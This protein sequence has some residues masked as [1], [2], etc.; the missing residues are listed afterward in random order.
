MN[1][2]SVVLK[3]G[4]VL[5]PSAGGM[6]SASTGSLQPIR[7]RHFFRKSATRFRLQL[8]GF[9][10]TFSKSSSPNTVLGPP[11]DGTKTGQP[12]ARSWACPLPRPAAFASGSHWLTDNG[13]AQRVA[14]SHAQLISFPVRRGGNGN[15]AFPRWRRCATPS[16]SEIFA[17]T[18]GAV[19]ES[20][21][22][23]EPAAH[24][25]DGEFWWI[26]GAGRKHLRLLARKNGRDSYG[27]HRE[28]SVAAPDASLLPGL[29]ESWPPWRRI[30]TK[31]VFTFGRVRRLPDLSS[32]SRPETSLGPGIA[33]AGPMAEEASLDLSHV[34]CLI[35]QDA[36]ARTYTC[37][38]CFV[39]SL[40]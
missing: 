16:R 3:A 38:A 10:A 14:W 25:S 6:I 18:E 12:S 32:R 28:F 4:D 7:S 17:K 11:L 35:L 9:S 39:F 34:R 1:S 21:V 37:G 26:H 36:S 30:S 20:A 31:N 27:E 19:A 15:T 8:D 22:R 13:S 40:T 24:L 2:S 33:S 23:R 29:K 5:C